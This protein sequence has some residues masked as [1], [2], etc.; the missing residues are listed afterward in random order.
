MEGQAPKGQKHKEVH[1]DFHESYPSQREASPTLCGA[2]PQAEGQDT[3]CT[4]LASEPLS[5]RIA[6]SSCRKGLLELC[7]QRLV[8]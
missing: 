6:E 7:N 5:G 1:T 4:T 2:Q 8:C 3:F